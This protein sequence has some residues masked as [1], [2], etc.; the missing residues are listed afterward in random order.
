[1]GNGKS[2][3]VTGP[4]P[5]GRLRGSRW[6]SRVHALPQVPGPRFQVPRRGSCFRPPFEFRIREPVSVGPAVIDLLI[7]VLG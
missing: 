4:G 6:G 3:G 2:R 5:P 1:M 7:Y